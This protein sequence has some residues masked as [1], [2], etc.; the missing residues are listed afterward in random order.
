MEGL[1]DLAAQRHAEA[2][3]AARRTGRTLAAE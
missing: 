3:E 1:K 2:L